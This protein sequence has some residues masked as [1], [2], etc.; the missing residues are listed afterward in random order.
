MS[1]FIL[2]LRSPWFG[3]ARTSATTQESGRNSDTNRTIRAPG[4][5]SVACLTVRNTAGENVGC[6]RGATSAGMAASQQAAVSRLVWIC[7][8]LWGWFQGT[9]AQEPEQALV[10]PDLLNHFLSLRVVNQCW[11]RLRRSIDAQVIP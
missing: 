8:S 11:R 9:H 7:A 6:G 4:V 5:F 1:G 10:W 2:P 3:D